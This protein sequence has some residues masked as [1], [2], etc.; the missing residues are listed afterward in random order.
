M[1]A[2]DATTVQ[3]VPAEP[4]FVESERRW[5]LP[6][7]FVSVV[8]VSLTIAAILIGQS[9]AGQ[10]IVDRAKKAVGVDTT[11][12]TTATT[13]DGTTIAALTSA[14]FDPEGDNEEHDS[15]APFVLDGDPSTAWTTERYNSRTF[16]I[17][18][19]VGIYV[20]LGNTFE[21]GQLKV[22]SPTNGWSATVHV[23]Q[24]PGGSVEEWGAA[25][26]TG[27]GI[28]AG[29]TTFDLDGAEGRYVLLWITDLGDGS[30]TRASVGELSVTTA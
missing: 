25:A 2:S 20:D 4:R 9:S 22:T 17:K 8:A 30:P 29:V 27:A 6:A 7:V 18:R 12:T 1:P 26:A 5:L 15:E 21:V 10:Q 28:A 13:A 16:G 19:G 14:A 11:P 3:S 24:A 23:A